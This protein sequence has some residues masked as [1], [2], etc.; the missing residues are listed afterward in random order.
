MSSDKTR[1]TGVLHLFWALAVGELLC[2]CRHWDETDSWSVSPLGSSL[3][4]RLTPPPS[5][6]GTT[7]MEEDP[8]EER[9]HISEVEPGSSI[10]LQMTPSPRKKRV[11]PLAPPLF[12]KK[13]KKTARFTFVFNLE[14]YALP[15]IS[16]KQTHKKK[17]RR[18]Q[19]V[20]GLDPH[21]NNKTRWR[22]TAWLG[23]SSEYIMRH[24]CVFFLLIKIYFRAEM[25]NE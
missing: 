17:I 16:K 8:W 21:H 1:T 23:A 12:L 9:G 13:K 14:S 15:Q 18:F 2:F 3:S 11:L 10:L 22:W 24:K 4:M 5:D 6:G 19:L 7:G 25:K 20:I